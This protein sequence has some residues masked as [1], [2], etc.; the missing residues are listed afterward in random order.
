MSLPSQVSVIDVSAV[1]E[2]L[3]TFPICA[4]PISCIASVPEFDS[5]DPEII[6]G[7][8]DVIAGRDDVI[9][10]RHDVIEG[11]DDVKSR[12]GIWCVTGS[13]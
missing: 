12:K 9:E 6:A 1:G 8:H 3:D 7:K 5:R 10:D 13:I 2:V 11:R 4:S